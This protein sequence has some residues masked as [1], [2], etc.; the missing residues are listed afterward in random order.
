MARTPKKPKVPG[1]TR[2]IVAENLANLVP[3]HYAGKP[4][5]TQQQKQLALDSGVAFSTVQRLMKKE[6]GADLETLELLATAFE[7]SVYQLVTPGL[8]AGNPQVIKGATAA[9]QKLYAELRR[10]RLTPQR[11][12]TPTKQPTKPVPAS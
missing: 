2:S 12:S 8:D 7:L 3:K 5:I 10:A 9:E 1:L 4:N 11:L 6:T